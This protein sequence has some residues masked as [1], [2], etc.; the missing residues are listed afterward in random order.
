MWPQ[1]SPLS[2]GV[3]RRHRSAF[4]RSDGTWAE[5]WRRG[6][7]ARATEHEMLRGTGDSRMK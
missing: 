4:A 2:L 7:G 5:V 1:D 6:R 3:C